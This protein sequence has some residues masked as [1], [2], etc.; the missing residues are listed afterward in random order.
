MQHLSDEIAECHRRARKAREHAEDT[1]DPLL[2]Q[3]FLAKERRWIVLAQSCELT[4]RFSSISD[5]LRR[6]RE[7]LAHDWRN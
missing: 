2:R 1:P 4:A 6:A 5:E 3:Y 7:Q